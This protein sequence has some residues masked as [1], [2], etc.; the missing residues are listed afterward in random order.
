[1]PGDF[2]IDPPW[3]VDRAVITHGHADHARA[4][5][6]AVLATP[7]TL[8]IIA[9]RYGRDFAGRA[10]GLAY[11]ETADINGVSVRFAPAGHV[12]GSAQAVLSHR[13]LTVVASGDYNRRRDPPCAA[14]QPVPCDVF[15]TEA[16]FGLPVFRHPLDSQEIGQLL[17][18]AAQFPDR[19]HLVGAY[20][21]GK[22]QRVIRLLREE[23][24]DETIY[25]HGAL[26][27]LNRLYEHFG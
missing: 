17:K 15:I 2:Y 20:A 21:L 13:G 26:E 12:L 18:S 23:G 9:E 8:A 22:A 4:G 25:V 10:Q 6:G 27:R 16:T 24:Y 7:E 5:H 19:A 3:P 1:E 11:G 14:F